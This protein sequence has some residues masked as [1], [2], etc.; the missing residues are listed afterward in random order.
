[1]RRLPP[2]AIA[3]ELYDAESPRD[4]QSATD[5]DDVIDAQ[6]KYAFAVARK[7][8]AVQIDHGH[9]YG[10]IRKLGDSA[11]VLIQQETRRV[12]ALLT[13][14]RD[15]AIERITTLVEADTAN[16]TVEYQNLRASIGKRKRSQTTRFKYVTRTG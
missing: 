10:K 2:P 4:L 9:E 14:N 13:S 12:L 6:V 3:A 5:S 16:V 8:G 1:M 15:I 11:A 7:S